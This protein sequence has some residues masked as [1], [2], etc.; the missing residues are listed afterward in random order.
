MWLL[1]GLASQLYLSNMQSAL[2]VHNLALRYS[3]SLWFWSIAIVLLVGLT[4]AFMY[5]AMCSRFGRG[6]RTALL[7]ALTLW[8]GGYVPYLI[9]YQIIGLYSPR[10]LVQ[11]GVVGLAEM[12]LGSLVSARIYR[13]RAAT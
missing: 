10:L 13:D 7:A 1:E 8:L 5:V 12:M 3:A 11:W 9:G 4:M 6:P 2:R